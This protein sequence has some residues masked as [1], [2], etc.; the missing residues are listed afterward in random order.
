MTTDVDGGGADP[1]LMLL[2]R[3]RDALR[4]LAELPLWQRPD[5]SLKTMAAGLDELRRQAEGQTVRVLGEVDARGIPGQDGTRTPGAWLLSVVPDLRPAEA[6]SLGKRAERLY[7]SALSAELAPTRDAVEAG[8]LRPH[9]EKLIVQTVEQ[10]TPP[11]LPPDHPDAVSAEVIQQAQELL[12]EYAP[13][14]SARDFHRLVHELRHAIDPNA[15]DRLAQDEAAQQRQ[16][17]FVMATE[18]SGM[19]FVQGLLTK[20][21]GA[22]LKAAL[23]A[24]SAP[25]PA[26]DG[27]LDPRFPGQRRH[28]ALHRLAETTLARHDVPTSHGSPVRIIVRVTAETLDA[29]VSDLAEQSAE[30]TTRPATPAGRTA[31]ARTPGPPAELDDG[32]PISRHTLARMLCDAELVPVLVDSRGTPLDVGRTLRDYTARQRIA[33]AERDRGCTWPGCTAP[34]SWCDAHHLISWDHG[35]PTNLDNAGL[36][37]GHHHRYVHATGATGRVIDG[38]VVWDDTSG[39]PGKAP[40]DA[41]HRTNHLIARL[42]RQWLVPRRE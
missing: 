8:T 21:C 15:D 27:T 41:P 40:P 35:G 4:E 31:V 38:R 14:L 34:A 6:G 10:I 36:L 19:T 13:V 18:A 3:A 20:E 25:Q 33:L 12:I 9:Q 42:V 1:V 17:T 24:W 26:E 37:C 22:A 32:T 23:D 16:R 30:G 29:A 5:A 39:P 7:R 11:D 2:S 28:D